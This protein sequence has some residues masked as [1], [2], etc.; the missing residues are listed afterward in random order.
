MGSERTLASQINLGSGHS[1]INEPQ[2]PAAS[3]R[4][5][6]PLEPDFSQM[7]DPSV[8]IDSPNTWRSNERHSSQVSLSQRDQPK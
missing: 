7:S 6:L 5:L 8:V 3:S 1:F 2:N 4:I